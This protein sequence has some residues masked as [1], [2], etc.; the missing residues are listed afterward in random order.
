[1]RSLFQSL[2]PG[3][4]VK[5]DEP[6]KCEVGGSG[7]TLFVDLVIHEIKVAIEVHGDQHKTL[8]PHFHGDQKGFEKS[9]ARDQSKKQ[10]LAD[11]NYTLIEISGDDAVKCTTTRLSRMIEKANK[12]RIKQ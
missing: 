10:A 5:E 11:A 9:Q 12:Q 8:V 7:T 3:F 4:K 6:I 1:M 2:F